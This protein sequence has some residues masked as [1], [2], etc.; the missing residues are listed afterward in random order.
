MAS[1][2]RASRLSRALVAGALLT[3]VTSCQEEEPAEDA[4]WVRPAEPFCDTRPR[5]SFCE[6]FSAGEL[7]G[8]FTRRVELGGGALRV[9]QGAPASEPHA[10]LAVAPDGAGLRQA[11]LEAE[12][13]QGPQLRIFSQLRLDAL[14][15]EGAGEVRLIAF[16]FQDADYTLA[17]GV[18]AVGEVF[19]VEEQGGAVV[20]RQVGER[21]FELGVWTSVRFDVD[22]PGDGTG[23]VFLRLG[24]D[25]V[26]RTTDITPP[27]TLGSASARFGLSAEGEAGWQVRYDNL[28]VEINQRAE[29]PEP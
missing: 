27:A 9:D 17:A 18:T 12:F 16:H 14:P 24:A 10:L 4:P 1:L 25:T 11:W 28:T 6:D 3:L 19:T 8:V 22:V 20:S 7:P 29:Q 21:R 5:L 26:V 23:L 15:S 2:S 13:E